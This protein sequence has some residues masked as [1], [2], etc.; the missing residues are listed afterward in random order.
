MKKSHTFDPSKKITKI[1]CIISKLSNWIYEIN[2]YH[3]EKRLV[4]V[5]TDAKFA[6]IF[7][8]KVEVFEIAEDEQLIGCELH[9]KCEYIEDSIFRGVTWIKIK[10]TY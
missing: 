3:G 9:E 5:H 10:L 1:E 4:E 2:F 8:E 7:D 6:A